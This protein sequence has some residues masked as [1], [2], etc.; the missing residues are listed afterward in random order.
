MSSTSTNR[1]QIR[2]AV[3]ILELFPQKDLER[4]VWNLRMRYAKFLA[5]KSDAAMKKKPRFSLED[6][7]RELKATRK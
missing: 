2:E 6:I 1:K 3:N 4:I 5:Q 7:N